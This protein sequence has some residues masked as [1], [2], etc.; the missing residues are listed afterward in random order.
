MMRVFSK[1][2]KSAKSKALKPTEAKIKEVE[3]LKIEDF[4]SGKV[5]NFEI[6]N[7]IQNDEK[8]KEINDKIEKAIK[9][10]CNSDMDHLYDKI[11][12]QDFNKDM[13]IDFYVKCG[14]DRGT[15][16]EN[17]HKYIIK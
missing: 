7:K 14:K 15:L 8:R 12:K 4:N 11:L 9:L 2:M 16:V 5:S 6:K 1:I 3:N 13:I 10:K 17:F